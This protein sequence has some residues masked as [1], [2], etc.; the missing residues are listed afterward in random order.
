MAAGSAA[1]CWKVTA[2]QA[3]NLD[4]SMFPTVNVHRRHLYLAH[5]CS[6]AC[7]EIH[8]GILAITAARCLREI[9]KE[10][11]ATFTATNLLLPHPTAF[12]SG[13]QAHAAMALST[14]LVGKHTQLPSASTLTGCFFKTTTATCQL[15]YLRHGIKL[16]MERFPRSV[17]EK[18]HPGG[19]IFKYKLF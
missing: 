10:R 17:A 18:L 3:A 14:A 8:T 5:L 4:T 6:A 1:T 7:T 9:V 16:E 2:Q 19:G 11:K 12:N 15:F 13:L